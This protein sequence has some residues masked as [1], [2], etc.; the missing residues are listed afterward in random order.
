MAAV[1]RTPITMAGRLIGD[2]RTSASLPN[3]AER[4]HPIPLPTKTYRPASPLLRVNEWPK[5]PAGVSVLAPTLDGMS[6][7]K[8]PQRPTANSYQSLTKTSELQA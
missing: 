8:T 4:N 7:G 2:R 3:R 1:A 5:K 6:G